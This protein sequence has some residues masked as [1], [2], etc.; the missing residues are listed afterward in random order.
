M[1]AYKPQSPMTHLSISIATISTVCLLGMFWC[2][3]WVVACAPNG[4]LR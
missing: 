2:G 4:S 3:A 1:A